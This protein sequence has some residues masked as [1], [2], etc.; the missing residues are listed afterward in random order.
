MSTKRK[1]VEGSDTEIKK[2]LDEIRRTIVAMDE[3]LT[4]QIKDGFSEVRESVKAKRH[5]DEMPGYV[6]RYQISRI[7]RRSKRTMEKIKDFPP[8]EVE[9]GGGKTAFWI[10]GK[11]RPWL[12]HRFGMVLPEQ[13]P[14]HIPSHPL[15]LPG[16][17]DD[18]DELVEE[19]VVPDPK[20]ELP[21][22]P[23]WEHGDFRCKSPT[24]P[25]SGGR[26]RKRDSTT[27]LCPKCWEE[28]FG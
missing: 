16:D 28:L 5:Q 27:G 4:K 1:C 26:T 19:P 7:V 22:K 14:E 10:W 3:R 25:R 11:I 9:G 17:S 2:Q 15:R 8:P 12:E 13:F 23:D 20:L 18:A 21:R 24:C 6:T